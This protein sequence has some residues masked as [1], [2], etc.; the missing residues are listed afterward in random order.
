MVRIFT[1]FCFDSHLHQSGGLRREESPLISVVV[2]PRYPFGSFRDF[3]CLSIFRPVF[4]FIIN[5]V[6]FSHLD[7]RPRPL[8]P[9]LWF[10]LRE[11]LHLFN[12]ILFCFSWSRFDLSIVES[13][14]GV[15]VTNLSPLFG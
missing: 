9:V 7:V 15:F 13:R 1:L 12:V 3:L 2:L 8:R 11:T 6:R 10:F 14:E 5:D 4:I